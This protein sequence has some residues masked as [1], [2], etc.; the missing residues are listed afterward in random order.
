MISVLYK[1]FEIS[2]NSKTYL[3][4][5]SKNWYYKNFK[6][7]KIAEKVVKGKH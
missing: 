2:L 3:Y 7:K 1:M 5:K 6:R 4:N